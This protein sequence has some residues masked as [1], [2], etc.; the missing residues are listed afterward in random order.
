MS[1][2]TSGAAIEL[3][4]IRII[5]IGDGGVGK[6][7]LLVRYAQDTFDT[8]HVPT[9]LTK[10]QVSQHHNGREYQIHLI[11]TAGQEEFKRIA[12]QHYGQVDVFLVCYSVDHRASLRNVPKS[13]GYNCI[14]RLEMFQGTTLLNSFLGVISSG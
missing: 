4:A 7:C 12:E 9:V 10:Y 6:T 8:E 1:R 2:A 5:I 14:Y 3:P 11:D 13:V